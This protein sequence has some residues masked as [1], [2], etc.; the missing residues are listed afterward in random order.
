MSLHSGTTTKFLWLTCK[1]LKVILNFELLLSPHFLF[2]IYLYLILLLKNQTKKTPQ[3]T[4][5]LWAKNSPSHVPLAKVRVNF[6][7]TG[8]AVSFCRTNVIWKIHKS[9]AYLVLVPAH[10]TWLLGRW[11]STVGCIISLFSLM[12]C[13]DLL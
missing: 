9:N 1:H 11:M 2:F 12:C 4:P 8:A 13:A 10:N 6:G 7:E 5:I 3:Q